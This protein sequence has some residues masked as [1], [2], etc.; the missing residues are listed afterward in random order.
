[1]GHR[2]KVIPNFISEE[3]RLKA[4][5][6]IDKYDKDNKL[7]P[8]EANPEVLV[9]PLE[10]ETTDLLRIYSDKSCVLHKQENG[11]TRSLYTTESFLS[12]WKEGAHAGEHIDAHQGYEFLEF[13]TV[14]YLN[15]DF[16]GGQIH[17][18]KQTFVYTPKA[19]DAVMFPST[20]EYS[21]GVF[22]L[23]KGRRYTIPM[24]HTEFS[25]HAADWSR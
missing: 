15:D 17:F 13:S 11:F 9:V 12:L 23:E 1:M 4:I 8:F 14:V 2:I 18:P 20:L 25:N 7:L 6:L 22:P 16:E 10:K 5:S 3:D 19:G 24:W 21:H